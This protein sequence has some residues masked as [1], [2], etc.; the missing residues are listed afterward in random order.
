MA[1]PDHVVAPEQSDTMPVLEPVYPLTAGLTPKML[2]RA[3]EDALTRLPDLP[4]W[5]PAPIMTEHNWP[6]F[7]DAMRTVHKPQSESELLPTSPS[8]ARLAF[9]ELLAN[10]LALTMVRQQASDTASGRCFAPP[11]KLLSALK[12]GLPFSMTN[13][14]QHAIDEITADQA[15]PKRMLR[16]LQGDVGS[17]KTLVALAAMLTVAE[18]GAQATPA[19]CQSQ[20]PVT[21]VTDGCRLAFG[22]RAHQHRRRSWT[23]N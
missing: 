19:S 23:P 8:R 7:A 2:R 16:M 22:S 12:A 18:T 5:I 9:D 1:H 14:Q 17:G 20:R 10:Q 13:A 4:E 6:N 11:G 21:P 3:I 15:A